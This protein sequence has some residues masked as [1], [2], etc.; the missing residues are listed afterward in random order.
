LPTQELTVEINIAP[1]VNLDAQSVV[2]GRGCVIG[3][4]G[5]GKSYLVGV[6][7]EELCRNGLPFLI[8]DTEGEYRSLKSMFDA[9]WVGED[10]KADVGTDIDFAHLFEESMENRVPVI[11]DV[12][13]VVNKTACVYRALETLYGVE[14][15]KRS[16]YLVIMEESDKFCPQVVRQKINPVEEI[17]VRGRK[18][19]IGLLVATQ[20]PANISKNVL[21]QCSYGFVGKL[22][23][24]NDLQAVSVLFEGRRTLEQIPMLETGTFMPFGLP[25][26]NPVK[27]KSRRVL[28]VGSTPT[29]G[30][31]QKKE[32]RM[33]SILKELKAGKAAAASQKQA[34]RTRA[35]SQIGMDAVEA[36]F[37]QGMAEEYA[38]RLVRKQYLLFG[39]E[40][41]VDSVELRYFQATECKL[42]VP[43]YRKN[44]YVEGYVILRGDAFVHMREGEGISFEKPAGGGRYGRTG[45]LDET[46]MKVFLELAH[47][48]K[49]DRERL[50]AASGASRQKT[51]GSIR[52]LERAG[53]IEARKGSYYMI[54]NASHLRETPIT[55]E[56]SKIDADSIVN[57][58][59]DMSKGAQKLLMALYPGSEI[60]SRTDICVPMYEITLRR[61]NRVRLFRIDGLYGK[62]LEGV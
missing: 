13:D 54:D 16:P 3:Q 45:R 41:S 31:F 55:V 19:G 44:E 27:I 38:K 30:S 23:I 40:E 36:S 14:E 58:D 56:K 49:A 53:L 62:S 48:R 2:T 60:L 61:G 1:D 25:E 24:D 22:S 33:G 32:V 28:H 43:T 9:I 5:S 10:K 42:R 15:E 57:Y 46:D 11:L 20:R 39:K 7:V 18:R 4:S 50:A 29:I 26:R 34:A 8:V 51:A 6:I 12:S 52:R 17:S 47:K 59:R 37:T 21:A 35:A